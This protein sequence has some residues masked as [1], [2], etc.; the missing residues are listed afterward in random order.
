MKYAIFG[1]IH[2]NLEGFQA[3]MEDA[4][5]QGAENLICL[6]DIV[7]YGADPNEC[8][9]IV[10]SLDCP[11]VKGNHDE[12]AT[13]TTN[14]DG[15][16]PLA[17]HAME[18]TR[19]QLSEEERGYLEQLKF[20]RQVKDFTIVHATLDTPGSWTY[21]TN[22]FD[23]M[24]SFSYQFTQL[25]FYG[26]THTPRIYQKGDSVEPLES[27]HINL[28]MG[29]KY[30]INVGSAGQPRD[31][32]WRVSYAIYDVENQQVYIRRLEYDIQVAQQKILDAGLPEMLA[33]R[34]SLGK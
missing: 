23:A 29:H 24:A 19:E 3:V 17:K 4:E 1:D 7:G 6:G 28:E 32:D 26:H 8:L 9:K 21:V 18:W 31:G 16:N 22:K 10:R 11:V 13:L 20:V 15:L 2:A 27:L 14:L 30:F 25:C 33:H 5:G 34:L 12:E